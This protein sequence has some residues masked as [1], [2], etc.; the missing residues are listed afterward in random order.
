LSGGLHERQLQSARQTVVIVNQGQVDCN[1]L[2]HGGIRKP[3]DNPRAMSLIGDLLSNLGQVILAVGVLDMGKSAA[4]V[5]IS[6]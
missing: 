5:R 2:L 4:R 1:A 6:A 3:L